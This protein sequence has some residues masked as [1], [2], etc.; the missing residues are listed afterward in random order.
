MTMLTVATAALLREC[1]FRADAQYG[2]NIYPLG[3]IFWFDET[4]LDTDLMMLSREERKMMWLLFAIRLKVWDGEKLSDGESSVW[5]A[6]RAEVPE[7]ALFH[8]LV[9][10]DD[11]SEARRRI[12][13]QAG[14]EG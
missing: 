8:R 9:L 2:I 3:S 6:A 14:E 11:E 13:K 4:P 10:S 1:R 5:E 12:E 7:W